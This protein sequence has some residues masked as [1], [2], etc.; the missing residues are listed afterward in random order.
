MNII[1]Y[2]L[3]M[4]LLV[5]FWTTKEKNAIVEDL[6]ADGKPL[7]CHL[8]SDFINRIAHNRYFRTLFYFRT[9]GLFTNILRVLYP[10]EKYFIIDVNTKI[11]GGVQAAH[12]FGTII[13]AENIGTNLYI[14]HLVTIGEKDGFKPIIGNNVQLHANCTIIGNITIGNDVIVG[15]GTV[16][17]RDIP[18]GSI[19]VGAKMRFL[20]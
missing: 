16:V 2:I 1:N 12:P 13:N 9:R 4:P 5:R 15:A 8:S 18:N 11:G 19:V 6:Y 17:T 14:N 7:K 10:K 3:Y 20:K